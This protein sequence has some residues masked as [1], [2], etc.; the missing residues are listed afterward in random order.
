LC[1]A[2]DKLPPKYSLKRFLASR[3]SKLNLLARYLYKLLLPKGKDLKALIK[4]FSTATKSVVWP[5]MSI[6]K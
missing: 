3:Q 4:P 6:K 5:A 2:R 1:I